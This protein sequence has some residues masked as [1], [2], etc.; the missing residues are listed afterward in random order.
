MRQH[1]PE[2]D[3]RRAAAALAVALLLPLLA[4]AADAPAPGPALRL[5]D[6]GVFSELD[7]KVRITP[8]AWELTPADKAAPWLRLDP[9]HQVLTVY[10]GPAP[11]I[12]YPLRGAVPVRDLPGRDLLS[13]ALQAEDSAALR[14]LV[15]ADVQVKLGAPARAED[16][17][18]DGV[19]NSLDILL[20]AKKLVQNRAAYREEYRTLRYPGGDVPRT[21][22]VCTDT[23]IRALRNAGWDLQREVHEDILRRP[24]AY[25]LEK[26]P[27]ANIDH[28]RIRNLVPWLQTRFVSVPASAPLRPGD[29]V[30]LDTFPRK[31]GPDHAGIVSDTRGPSGNPMIIN[32]WT[33]G[34]TESE[35]DLLA[36]V[37]VTHRFRAP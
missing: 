33:T 30:L 5:R 24:R 17:D 37:P 8:P 10:R 16:Q 21:E 31:S 9:Q 28:R 34:Y 23:L 32:N 18:G 22:G 13:A 7:E 2:I 4:R 25:N 36:F 11:L 27:D 1:H 26:A 3:K 19:V 29:I 15:P 35:M 14:A 6:V 20:G 12:A